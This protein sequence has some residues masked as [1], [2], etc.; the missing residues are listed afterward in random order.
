[1]YAV[2][3]TFHAENRP[4]MHF[5]IFLMVAEE[6]DCQLNSTFKLFV[7]CATRQID[8]IEGGRSALHS[9]CHEGHCDIIRELLDRGAKRTALVIY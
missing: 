1:M 2:K 8:E 3:H 5:H 4:S 7:F 9:A 6:R